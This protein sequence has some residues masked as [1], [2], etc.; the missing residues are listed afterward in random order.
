MRYRVLVAGLL[1]LVGG[2]QRALAYCSEDL[3]YSLRGEFHRSDIVALVRVQAVT[4]L[5][6]NRSPT[7]LK[8]PLGLGNI[9]GGLDPY[10]GAYY[11]VKLVKAFKGNPHKRFRIFSENT[12]ARTPL[13]IGPSLLVF[14]T[15]AKVADEYQRVGDL[16]VDSCGNS[17]L[18]A[19]VPQRVR[20]VGRLGAHR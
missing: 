16:T 3:D 10:V 18:A 9:P 14:L 15:R 5:D 2:S 4:W 6:E 7:K 1:L 12:T 11:S 8:Q 19:K 13:R 17:A 20:L